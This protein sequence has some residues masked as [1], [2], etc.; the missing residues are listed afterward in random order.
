MTLIE[1]RGRGGKLIDRFHSPKFSITIGRAF[2]NDLIVEDDYV[3]EHHLRLVRTDVGWKLEDQGSLNGLRHTSGVDEEGN[4]ESGAE[5]RI[6]QTRLH[7]FDERHPAQPAI[8]L[9]GTEERLARLAAVPVFGGL[10]LAVALVSTLA[11]YWGSVTEWEPES[12]VSPI[13]LKFIMT[14]AFASVWA[15]VGRLLRHK[16]YFLVHLSLWLILGLTAVGTNFLSQW[17]AYNFGSQ[18][19]EETLLQFFDLITL[20]GVTWASLTL[21]TP[22][23]ARRRLYTAAGV[24][25]T[26][27][28]LSFATAFEWESWFSNAP[29]YYGRILEPSLLWA[30]PISEAQLLES[31]P[32]LFDA[33][34]LAAKEEDD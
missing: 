20:T 11:A 13:A 16:A 21:A 23:T 8:P 29:G 3:S 12:V 34:D 9:D 10:M 5:M 15:L 6:G 28:M 7:I 33:A 17:V 30:E 4:V 26:A 19:L 22:L 31:L 1:V 32:D 25:L 14:A 2:D 24:A 27:S 18:A